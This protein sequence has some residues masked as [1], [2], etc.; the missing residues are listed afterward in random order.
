[1]NKQAVLSCWKQRQGLP[2]LRMRK[3]ETD[4]ISNW[5]MLLQ[6]VQEQAKA[7]SDGVFSPN[8]EDTVHWSLKSEKKGGELGQKLEYQVGDPV[9]LEQW[10]GR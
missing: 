6:L 1:M 9:A 4:A 8:E 7:I 2:K 10:P 3:A 5:M